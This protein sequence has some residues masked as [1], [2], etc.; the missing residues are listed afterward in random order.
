MLICSNTVGMG[1]KFNMVGSHVKGLTTTYYTQKERPWTMEL[2]YGSTF[3]AYH[4]KLRFPP[5]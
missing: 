4:G 2:M 3:L 5:T 1:K